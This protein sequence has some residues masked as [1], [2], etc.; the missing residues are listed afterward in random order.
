MCGSRPSGVSSSLS[1]SF[2][3]PAM[4][5][6][7]DTHDTRHDTHGDTHGDTRWKGEGSTGCK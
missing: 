3:L 2:V 6:V 1:S 7:S 5:F 4:S